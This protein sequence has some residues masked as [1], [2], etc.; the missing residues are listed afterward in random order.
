MICTSSA[1]CQD[2]CM[3]TWVQPKL[4]GRKVPMN[5]TVPVETHRA[6]TIEAERL[7]ISRAVYVE[8]L[9]ARDLGLPSPLNVP[10]EQ[11]DELLIS[12]TA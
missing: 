8:H 10:A 12:K 9:V 3:T 6:A 2:G 7:G 5:M 11:Q 1:L 4:V